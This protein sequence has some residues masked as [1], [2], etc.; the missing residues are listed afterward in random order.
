MKLK[1]AIALFDFI[2]ADFGN[3]KKDQE[4]DCTDEQLAGL[5]KLGLVEPKTAKKEA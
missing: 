5:V 1:K 3:V 2:S 4:L